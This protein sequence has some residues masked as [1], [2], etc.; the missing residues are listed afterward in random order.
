MKSQSFISTGGGSL[1]ILRGTGTKILGLGGVTPSKT[2]EFWPICF[3]PLDNFTAFLDFS[4]LMLS[5]SLLFFFLLG[6]SG[7][8]VPLT[9]NFGWTRPCCFHHL[10]LSATCLFIFWF[11]FVCFF[12]SAVRSSQIKKG[13]GTNILGFRGITSLK[14]HI[15]WSIRILPKIF[16]TFLFLYFSLLFIFLLRNLACILG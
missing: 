5:F 3:L 7:G 4:L 2:H 6:I 13:M 14:T 10:C 1:K 12:P 15:F 16:A 8:D 11:V 9:E